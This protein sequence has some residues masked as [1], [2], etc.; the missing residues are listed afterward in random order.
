RAVDAVTFG[1]WRRAIRPGTRLIDIGCAQ[2]RSTFKLMDLPIGIVAFDVSK[3]LVRQAI[4]RQRR[5]RHRARATFFVGDASVLPFVNEV[6]DYVLVYGVLHHLPD[7]RA[8]CQEISRV[9][10]LGGTCFFCENNQTALRA[11]FEF[12]QRLR[13]LWYEEAGKHAQMSR[14]ELQR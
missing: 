12:V 8:T 10:R 3:A 13:P 14:Q 11:A 2:G 6:F 5:G 9:L 7:P 4:A 1:D